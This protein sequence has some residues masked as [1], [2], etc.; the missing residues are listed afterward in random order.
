VDLVLGDVDA[1]DEFLFGLATESEHLLSVGTH[2]FQS[3]DQFVLPAESPCSE[4]SP[5]TSQKRAWNEYP[6]SRESRAENR[7][8]KMAVVSMYLVRRP[9]RGCPGIDNPAGLDRSRKCL[10]VVATLGD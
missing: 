8:S 1:V 4:S 3:P 6:G 2:L 5:K 9:L 10:I 7:N